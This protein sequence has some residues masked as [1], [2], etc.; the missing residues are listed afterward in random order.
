MC[1]RIEAETQ[2]AVSFTTHAHQ[3]TDHMARELAGAVHFVRV[4]MDGVGSTYERIRGRS[5]ATLLK[6]LALVRRISR[7]G[8]NLVVNS[9]TIGDL[10]AA[11]EAA[12]ESGASELLLLPERRTANSDGITDSDLRSLKRWILENPQ[13]RLAVADGAAQNDISLAH[14]FDDSEGFD[15]YAHVDA[16]A[17]LRATSFSP[18]GTPIGASIGA[19]LTRLRTERIAR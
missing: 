14:P 15:E 10:D 17:T 18:V 4:S 12:F 2:L 3:L 11:A 7:F 1:R 8:V 16:A 19:A 9:A 5:F 6:K 13:F